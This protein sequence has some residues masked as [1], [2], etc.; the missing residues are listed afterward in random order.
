MSD[1]DDLQELRALATRLAQ[2]RQADILVYSG[3]MTRPGDGS[4]AFGRSVRSRRPNC[5][6]VLR[7]LGGSADAAYRL[8]RTLRRAYRRVTVY[9]DDYC[10][11][12][13]MLPAVAADELVISDFGELGP[14]DL[15]SQHPAIPGHGE[16]GLA[17][18]QGLNAI[19]AE[20]QRSFEQY[21]SRFRARRA[22]GMTT[23]AAIEQASALAVGLLGPVFSQIDPLQVAEVERGMTTARL[24]VQRLGADHLKEGALDRL[25]TGYPSHDFVID[26][27]EASDLLR[28]V[29]AP[30]EEEGLFLTHLEP[31]VTARRL[32]G[33]LLLLDDA[34]SLV[35]PDGQAGWPNGGNASA[36]EAADAEGATT[37][38]VGAEWTGS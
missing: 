25:L 24:Y 27:E 21:L 5:L 26:R 32:Q 22:L 18:V 16:S 31:I 37:G 35:D 23:R 4:M 9:V 28:T 29:R 11:G 30:T 14:L 15:T 38:E 13:G 7:T 19:R 1:G 20:A 2:L 12:A 36:D 3:E 10:K 8:A 34:L 17:L 6:L 33:R